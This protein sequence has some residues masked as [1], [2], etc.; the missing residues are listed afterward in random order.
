MTSQQKV[1]DNI[2]PEWNELK[3]VPAIHTQNFLKKCTGKVLDLGSGSGRNLREIKN[4]KMYL[5][6]FSKEMI[7]LA[8]AHAKKKKLDAEFRV[9]NLTRIP[10]ENNFF[11]FAICNSALH[12]VETEKDR[13]KV[14]QELY[15]VLKPKAKAEISVWHKD[16]RRFKNAP[17]EKYI[18]WHD[19]GAR[20]YYLYS[21][22]EIYELFEKNK[23]KII[24]KENP[25]RSIVFIVQKN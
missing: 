15:R 17:K 9:A 20:Y 19:K 14:V 21:A 1:W 25:K 24:F 12:C 5:V 23:F 22:K 13:E 4:G 2:A 16:T 11:D 6:D 10:Y 18:K 8:K 3:K 7:E